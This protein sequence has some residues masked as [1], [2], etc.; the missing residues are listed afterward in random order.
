MGLRWTHK[1]EFKMRLICT[2]KRRGKWVQVEWKWCDGLNRDNLKHKLIPPTTFAK[3]HHSLPYNILFASLWGLHPNVTFSW[4]SRCFKAL[5][6]H[7]FLKWSLF[8]KIQGKYFI[9]FKKFFLMVYSVPQSK[10]IWPLI[11]KGLWFR[12]KFSILFMPFLLIIIHA[13]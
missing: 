7:I 12:V 4:D 1:W 3:R 2:T 9:T 8:W 10:L 5:D 11:L 6:A 13:N